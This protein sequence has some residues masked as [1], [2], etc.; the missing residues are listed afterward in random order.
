MHAIPSILPL[1]VAVVFAVAGVIQLAGPAPLLRLFVEW[2]YGRG[3]NWVSGTAALVDASFLAIPQ[4]R[5]WGVAL[6]AFILFGSTV[7]LLEHRKYYF[8]LPNMLLLGTLPLAL[9]AG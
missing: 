5:A 9:V 2:G 1:A 7:V 6:G 4:I 8:A 3:F